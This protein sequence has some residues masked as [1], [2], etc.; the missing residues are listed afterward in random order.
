MSVIIVSDCR[1]EIDDNKIGDSEFFNVK[2]IYYYIKDNVIHYTSKFE[3]DS[4][5]YEDLPEILVKYYRSDE[6]FAQDTSI[7]IDKLQYR[8]SNISWPRESGCGYIGLFA[9]N[10]I[11]VL[12]DKYSEK[13][14]YKI[15]EE[16]FNNRISVGR[17]LGSNDCISIFEKEFSKYK[18]QI[19]YLTKDPND[20]R[21]RY[22][23][24]YD[25]FMFMFDKR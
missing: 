13:G 8:K 16:E 12:V 18:L 9:D 23:D 20:P 1:I 6:G 21:S 14:C 24:K 3:L 4:T 10:R 2:S 17:S 7:I 5:K 15:N 11:E 22:S 19:M 25:R